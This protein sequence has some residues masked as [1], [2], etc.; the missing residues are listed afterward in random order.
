VQAFGEKVNSN[1]EREIGDQR[2]NTIKA[3]RGEGRIWRKGKKAI[4]DSS[5]SKEGKVGKR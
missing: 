5:A 3:L 4:I 2:K 1:L